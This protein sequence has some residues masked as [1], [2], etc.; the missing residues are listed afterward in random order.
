MTTFQKSPRYFV[1]SEDHVKYFNN[2]E[3]WSEVFFAADNDSGAFVECRD[4]RHAQLVVDAM[5]ED[6][7]TLDRNDV[8]DALIAMERSVRESDPERIK[9]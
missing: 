3:E 1:D 2:R 4:H 8:E 9:S 6:A 7:L 5:N